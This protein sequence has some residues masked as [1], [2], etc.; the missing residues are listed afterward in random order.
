MTRRIVLGV[1][2]VVALAGVGWAIYRATRPASPGATATVRRGRIEA[3]VDALGSLQLAR[4]V[5]VTAAV[6][7]TVRH[8]AVQPGDRVISGTLLVELDSPD[9]REA[10][11]QAQNAVRLR[12]A[13]LEAALAAPDQATIDLAVARLKR[14]TALRQNA[15]S[16]YDAIAEQP[17][18]ESS[19]EA[20]ALAAAKLEY[21]IAQSEYDRT[22]RGASALDLD[23]LRV[24]VDEARR[25]LARSEA[26]LE[27]LRVL[28]PL[29]GVVLAVSV[30]AGANVYAN[31]AL[32]QV[33]DLRQLQVRAE[34]SELDV[35]AVA[36]GQSV[37]LWLDAFPGVQLAG[38][39]V[40]VLPAPS[41][42]RGMT[43]YVAVIA[44]A[45][46]ELALRPGMGVN[47]QITTGLEE[48]ALL[49]PRRAVRTVGF[50][51]VVRVVQGRKVADVVV[52]TGLSNG[53]EVQV[54]TG[55][56]EGQ[57]VLID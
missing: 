11:T 36:A 38:E 41:T 49:V 25:A 57:Q 51:Q 10:L 27:Q 20:L 19:D 28:A 48:A 6:G 50:E 7:G 30:Q 34:V 12:E 23:R 47:V 33:A 1:L 29:D 18:A 56:S 8:V 31:N 45:G 4:Q 9:V 14:A 53:D 3:R 37:T 52:T 54:L 16:D 43:A 46:D 17:D 21:Q 35:A 40:R 55:L 15:Q 39:V 22:M 5:E 26:R 32:V 24:S 44:F 13:E 42:A 2:L